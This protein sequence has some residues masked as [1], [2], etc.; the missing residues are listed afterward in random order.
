MSDLKL[1]KFGDETYLSGPDG[2]YINSQNES[3]F[4]LSCGEVKSFMNLNER[5]GSDKA[6]SSIKV[7]W[8]RY[9]KGLVAEKKVAITC[10]DLSDIIYLGEV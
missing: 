8:V 6:L 3:I 1:T 7:Y 4:E 5:V 2:L 10:R 9:E